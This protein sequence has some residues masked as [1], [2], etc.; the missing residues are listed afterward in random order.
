[1]AKVLIDKHVDHLPLDRQVKIFARSGLQIAKSTL[2][3]WMNKAYSALEPVFD[4]LA[5][6][7]KSSQSIQVDETTYK[8]QL[9]NK[10]MPKINGYMWAYWTSP[11]KL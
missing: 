8:V 2:C 5:Q 10:K 11:E 9:N 3:N 7:V 4:A 6:Q 1:V